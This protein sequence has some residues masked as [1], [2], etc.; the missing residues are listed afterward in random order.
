MNMR[1]QVT[2]KIVLLEGGA[3]APTVELYQRASGRCR[4]WWYCFDQDGMESETIATFHAKDWSAAL[5][6]GR[7]R[8][9]EFR[10]EK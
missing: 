2:N 1:S 4:L 8:L 7:E 5:R 9:R 6:K 10:S 3:T